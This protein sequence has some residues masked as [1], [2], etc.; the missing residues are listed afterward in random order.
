MDAV[1]RAGSQS[2]QLWEVGRQAQ[3]C[4]RAEGKTAAFRWTSPAHTREGS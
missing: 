1:L 3:V 4:S 2:L